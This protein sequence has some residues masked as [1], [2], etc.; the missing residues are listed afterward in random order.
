M[1]LF[2]FLKFTII[3]I[4]NKAFIICI[5]CYSFSDRDSPTCVS[6]FISYFPFLQVKK[7]NKQ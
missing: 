7:N 6:G 5:F 1:F 4:R 3:S 2:S